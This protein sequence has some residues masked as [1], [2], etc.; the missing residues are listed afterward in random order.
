[1]PTGYGTESLRSIKLCKK[2]SMTSYAQLAFLVDCMDYIAANRILGDVVECGVWEG[3]SALLIARQLEKESTKQTIWLYDTFDGMTAPSSFDKKIGGSISASKM[4]ATT[5]KSRGENVWAF[6]PLVEVQKNIFSNTV[7][8]ESRFK[9]VVGDVAKTLPLE[10][11]KSISL[12]RLDTD[13]YESTKI[14]LEF[15]FKL[16]SPGGVIIIDDYGHWEGS[17]RATDEF[18]EALE[19]YP[20]LFTVGSSRILLKNNLVHQ[21]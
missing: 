12:L 9:F 1:M 6:A 11:P 5:K 16:V 3:G 4:L 15:L 17:K 7:L 8:P 20:L 14:E 19:F 13:W 2:F 10:T 18:F 21:S